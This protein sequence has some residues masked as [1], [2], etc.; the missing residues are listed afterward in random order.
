MHTLGPSVRTA[1]LLTLMKLPIE[2]LRLLVN[3]NTAYAVRQARGLDDLRRAQALRFAIF[4][5]ELNEGL[6][7]SHATG[8]DA[9]PFDP[10]CDHLLVEHAAT[11]EIV[12]TYRLQTGESAARNLGYYSA[13][14][15]DFS[16]Y[17]P[18]RREMIEL[19][20]ACVHKEHRN[21]VVLGLLWKGIADYALE[22]GAR[23]LC[24][25]SSLTS[26]DAAVGAGAYAEL[27]RKHLA[28]PELRTH[29]LPGW[30]CSLDQL[31]AETPKI[32][33]LLRAYLNM[34]ARICGP[35]ALDR[36]FKTIDFL[37]WLDLQA[38]PAAVRSR[39]SS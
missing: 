29:P 23:Y 31:P 36:H 25:C 37:T 7:G 16:A 28:R 4:N 30:E 17:E 11:G 19:G 12:G 15:F 3:K 39:Y 5:V 38:L 6:A 35:P 8:L 24:G 14:E 33:K 2:A 9:D 21:M 1:G 34:G 26:Q 32:P 27:C 22:R 20:R 13:Q 18:L 10:V